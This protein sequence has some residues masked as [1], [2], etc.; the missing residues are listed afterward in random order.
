MRDDVLERCDQR[1]K[2]VGV[3]GRRVSSL[4]RVDMRRVGPTPVLVEGGE[5]V[6]RRDERGSGQRRGERDGA[7]LT[8]RAESH[9]LV[10]TASMAIQG[11]TG[12]WGRPGD[13]LPCVGPA[14]THSTLIHT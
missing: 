2:R 12:V 10:F 9:E 5:G 13:Q 1:R 7:V 8:I 3:A 14:R 11:Q 6:D 4:G